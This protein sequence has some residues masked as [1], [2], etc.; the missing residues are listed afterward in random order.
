[1]AKG[2]TPRGPREQVGPSPVERTSMLVECVRVPSA[3][4]LALLRMADC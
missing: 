2:L 4:A 1:M 3:A